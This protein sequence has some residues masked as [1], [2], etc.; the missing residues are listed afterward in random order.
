MCSKFVKLTSLNSLTLGKLKV[1]FRLRSFIREIRTIRS[2]YKFVVL[3]LV[4]G[5]SEV[6]DDV[7][8]V[9]STDGET[10]GG[11]R[12]VLFGQFLGRQL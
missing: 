3:N 11:R 10:H 9:L 4:E 12:D 1:N 8:D 6:F 2:L 5:L 7:V